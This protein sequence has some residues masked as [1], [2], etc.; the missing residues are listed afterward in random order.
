M[1]ELNDLNRLLRCSK[2]LIVEICFEVIG[3]DLTSPNLAPNDFCHAALKR[4]F[5][6]VV[7]SIEEPNV[8]GILFNITRMP[9]I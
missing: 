3:S 1:C 4:I 7:V 6:V 8:I 2:T 5:V 9:K